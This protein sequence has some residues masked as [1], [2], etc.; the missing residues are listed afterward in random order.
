VWYTGKIDT[1]SNFNQF[2][3]WWN[4]IGWW[5]GGGGPPIRVSSCTSNG[6][7]MGSVTP[8]NSQVPANS[9]LQ[10]YSLFVFFDP[11]LSCSYTTAMGGS[12]QVYLLHLH[13]HIH[14]IPSHPYDPAILVLIY[15]NQSDLSIAIHRFRAEFDF[16]MVPWC[17]EKPFLTA[18][19]P[20][21]R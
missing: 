1:L 7:L 9:S 21:Q 19:D 11:P 20:G 2:T 12:P 13:R 17:T 4:N 10:H 3:V 16:C 5:V 8:C 15:I 6:L 14:C 18:I